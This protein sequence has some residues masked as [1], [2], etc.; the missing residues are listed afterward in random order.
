MDIGFIMVVH[1]GEDK[2]ETRREG[3]PLVYL[4]SCLLA[5]SSLVTN[6]LHVVLTF[7][8]WSLL[9]L[10]RMHLRTR[11]NTRESGQYLKNGDYNHYRT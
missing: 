1:H 9:Y 11:T 8:S 3:K 10:D 7:E 5:C 6:H 4:T 2:H